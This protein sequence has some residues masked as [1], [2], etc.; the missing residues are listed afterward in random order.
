MAGL[1]NS[2]PP[3]AAQPAMSQAPAPQSQPASPM[4]QAAQGTSTSLSDPILQKIEAGIE[5]KIPPQMKANY[6]SSVNAGMA[7]MFGQGNGQKLAQKFKSSQNINADITSGIANVF[8]VILNQIMSKI[9]PQQQKQFAQTFLP[10]LLSASAT[11]TCHALDTAEK[12]GALKVTPQ[13]A[14]QAIHDSALACLQKLGVGPSQIKQMASNGKQ[15]QAAPQGAA[16]QSPQPG[17]Q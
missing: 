17:M 1:L 4:P 7:A 5:T 16:P 14:A 8:A 15:A 2:A 10:A 11:L 9:P 12:V 13:L 3:Q 6:L